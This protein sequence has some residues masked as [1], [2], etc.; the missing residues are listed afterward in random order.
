MSNLIELSEELGTNIQELKQWLRQHGFGSGKTISHRATRE[1]RAHFKPQTDHPMA[2][3]LMERDGLGA[4][5]RHEDLLDL[6]A[7]IKV[8]NRPQL[9]WGKVKRSE[10]DVLEMD[11]NAQRD[12]FKQLRTSAPAVESPKRESEEFNHE[13]QRG[14]IDPL[15][16]GKDQVNISSQRKSAPSKE[17]LRAQGQHSIFGSLASMSVDLD[18]L[19]DRKRAATMGEAEALQSLSAGVKPLKTNSKAQKKGKKGK[20]TPEDFKAK[21]IES[22]G[23]PP[24]S[25]GED[26]PKSSQEESFKDL[27]ERP[28]IQSIRDQLDRMKGELKA[29][30]LE[31]NTLLQTI[32]RLEQERDGLAQSLELHTTPQT[33]TTEAQPREVTSDDSLSPRLIWDHF[34]S[35]GLDAH[36]ARVALLELLDHP[37]RGPELV[38]SLKHDHPRSLTRGFAIVCEDDVCRQ[39]ADTF[40]RQGLIEFSEKHLCTV[41][42]GSVSRGWYRRLH[43]TATHTQR[44]R[45]LVVG[46]DDHDY[47]LIKQLDRELGG[48]TWEFITG[49]SRV[50]QTTAN[51]KV[52]KQS[53]VLLWGGTHLPHALSNVIKSAANKAGV[54]QCTLPPGRRSVAYLCASI[55]RLWGLELEIDLDIL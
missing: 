40:A 23:K 2:S 13:V 25:T 15:N 50:D 8:E 19:T 20:K 12:F 10:V 6:G 29:F 1:A 46:G 36:Q 22:L 26:A 51:A 27:F 53:A 9:K 28:E 11:M 43:L 48:M 54:P 52:A 7:G 47:Q 45:I 49:A 42:Q 4:V 21:G 14:V 38:Y 32:T 30:T 18:S 5:K 41:C 3:A 35:F 31:R 37:Q 16:K 55:L 33:K 24:L 39:V 44:E 17:Q 34:E